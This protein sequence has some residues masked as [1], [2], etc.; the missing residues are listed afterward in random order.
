MFVNIN[1]QGSTVQRK[2]TEP[3]EKVKLDKEAHQD[4]RQNVKLDSRWEQ[5][6]CSMEITSFAL[7]NFA[8]EKLFGVAK[9][10]TMNTP[11]KS[12]ECRFRLH[13]ESVL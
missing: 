7:N 8:L 13:Y 5:S 2:H 4:A 6:T 3:E 11:Q 1:K 12:Q 9:F 10:V